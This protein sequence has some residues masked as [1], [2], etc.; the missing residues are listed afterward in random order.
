[1]GGTKTYSVD[2]RVI[3]ATNR[4]LEQLVR[5]G[6]FRADLYYR[7]NVFPIELPALRDRPDDIP[8]LSNYF[9]TKY[10][11]R[12]GKDIYSISEQCMKKLSGYSWPGN[13]R[14]LENIIERAVILTT[15]DVLE[16]TQQL[17]KPSELLCADN[18]TSSR[19]EDIEREH[20]IKI[21]DQTEWQIHGKNGAARI[22][23]MNPSTLRSMMKKLGI[24][25]K[26]VLL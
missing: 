6:K 13:I 8:A 7:L 10:S 19:L 20:I 5:E 24:R 2:V 1:M 15:G 25:K 26:T 18:Q 22:L 21:L 16:V 14:E 9:M 23:D 3:A 11:K 12:L 17:V 4:D